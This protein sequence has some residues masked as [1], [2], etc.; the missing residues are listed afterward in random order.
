MKF[1]PEQLEPFLWGG[2]VED[3]IVDHHRWSV[4]HSLVF[5]YEGR[6]YQTHYD[7]PAT[8]S[9]DCDAW[10]YRTEI[11]CQEVEA[12][13]ELTTVYKPVKASE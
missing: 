8:E 12:V 6:L 7:A 9:Q 11:E 3:K 1:T 13:Q 10:G 5:E 4:T 2:A